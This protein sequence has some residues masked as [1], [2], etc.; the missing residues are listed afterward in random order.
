MESAGG[1]RGNENDLV[2]SFPEQE[3]QIQNMIEQLGS[4]QKQVEL[5]SQSKDFTDTARTEETSQRGSLRGS[6]IVRVG[7]QATTGDVEQEL[8]IQ[9]DELRA[10]DRKL[11]R[12]ADLP[13]RSWTTEDVR[14]WLYQLA[15]HKDWNQCAEELVRAAERVVDMNVSGKV[16][17]SMDS[18]GWSELGV[19]GSLTRTRAQA[20][21][22]GHIDPLAK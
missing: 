5:L 7:A 2:Q 10:R 22:G 6:T 17:E 3:N 20:E 19:T 15:G 4:L 1:T 21:L 18:D 9:R 12:L 8:L 13:V 11:Q 16:L 14:N